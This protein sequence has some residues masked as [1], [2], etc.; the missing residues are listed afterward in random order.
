MLEEFFILG[1]D[2][3]ISINKP[4]LYLIPAFND[5]LKSDKGKYLNGKKVEGDSDG[6]KKILSRRR[7]TFVYFYCCYKTDIYDKPDVDRRRKALNLSG[8]SS[9]DICSNTNKAIEEYNYL[10]DSIFIRAYRAACNNVESLISYLDGV[11]LTAEDEVGRLKYNPK[12]VLELSSSIGKTITD[13]KELKAKV[14]KNT[15]DLLKS[16]I[17]AGISLGTFE[18][19]ESMN[20]YINN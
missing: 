18:D 15:D 3:L 2:G 11:D 14:Y 12:T 16:K 6:R 5:I 17:R 10:Q 1:E 7:L 9:D 13:L 19:P 8:L 4:S 20:K